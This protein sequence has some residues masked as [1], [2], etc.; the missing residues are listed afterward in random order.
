MLKLEG[1]SVRLGDFQ[2][3]DISLHVRAGTYLTLLGSTGTGK[4]ALLA[5][6][7]LVLL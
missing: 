7:N 5:G 3:R 2:L 4:T 6:G 1:I